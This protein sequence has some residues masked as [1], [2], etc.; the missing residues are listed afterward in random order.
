MIYDAA[1]NRPTQGRI[2]LGDPLLAASR[3]FDANQSGA[4]PSNENDNE[5]NQTSTDVIPASYN[6]V[7][8]LK[9]ASPE[10]LYLQTAYVRL[11]PNDFTSTFQRWHLITL[12]Q[13]VMVHR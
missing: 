11:F 6:P 12:S 10:K 5:S 4:Q 2:R 7:V 3:I 8:R 13:Q 9:W 1:T